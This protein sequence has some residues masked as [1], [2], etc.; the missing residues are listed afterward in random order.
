LFGTRLDCVSTCPNCGDA[1]EF[2]TATHD[3]TPQ[4][5]VDDGAV[6]SLADAGLTCRRPANLDLHELAMQGGPIDSR[7]LLE[8]CV[9]GE[10]TTLVTLSDDQCERALAELAQTDPGASIEIAITCSC[11]HEWVDEFD[12]RSFLLSELTDWAIRSLRDVHQI[13]SRYGWSES[14]IL[15]MSPWRKSI[16]LEACGN[17]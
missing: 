5:N 17:S 11:S 4:E 15:R 7:R 3:I 12:I 16:Y 14:E 2:S 6:V 13:A 10:S 8:R 1:V 9:V